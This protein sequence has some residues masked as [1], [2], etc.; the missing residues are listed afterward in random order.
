MISQFNGEKYLKGEDLY[1][2]QG[3]RF[4]QNFV[5]G[6]D[7]GEWFGQEKT[8]KFQGKRFSF[9]NVGKSSRKNQQQPQWK[10]L[11]LEICVVYF[12]NLNHFKILNLKLFK[13]HQKQ[14]YSKAM[15][16]IE[17]TEKQ[18]LVMVWCFVDFYNF[19]ELIASW[20]H[21]L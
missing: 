9:F 14:I 20:S 12:T 15:F 17:T 18:H 19:H 11:T 21:S 6:N 7:P 8:R 3:A 4:F 1:W 10:L 5:A 16:Q 2:L 13:Q